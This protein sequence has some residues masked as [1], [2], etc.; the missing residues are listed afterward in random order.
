MHQST[1]DLP[2]WLGCGF[3]TVSLVFWRPINRWIDRTNA[4]VQEY[5]DDSSS[6]GGRS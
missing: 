5:E 6:G 3:V 2:F 4:R 1:F